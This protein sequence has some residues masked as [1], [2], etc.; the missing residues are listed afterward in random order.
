MKCQGASL[1]RKSRESHHT[2]S[3]LEKS[4]EQL[5]LLLWP[6]SLINMM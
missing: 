2:S 6:S 5:S 1:I 4:I 3:T